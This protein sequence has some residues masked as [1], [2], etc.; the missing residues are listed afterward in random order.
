MP[1]QS[2]NPTVGP[3]WGKIV[4]DGVDFLLTLPFTSRVTVEV[5]TVI[6]AAAAPSASLQG[7]P[8]RADKFDGMNRALIGSGDVHARCLDGAVPIILTTWSA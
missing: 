6:A 4:D 7:H 5:R 2:P 1:T 8:V 3:A